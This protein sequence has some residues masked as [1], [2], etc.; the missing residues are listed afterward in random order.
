M[1]AN[2]RNFRL[3]FFPKYQNKIRTADY[4]VSLSFQVALHK[5]GHVRF[6]TVPFNPLFDHVEDFVFLNNI[7][8]IAKKAKSHYREKHN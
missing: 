5:M 1:N 2:T 7:L 3:N 8:Q 4:L 6:L